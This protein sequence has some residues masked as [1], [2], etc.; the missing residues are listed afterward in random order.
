LTGFGVQVLYRVD[1]WMN[2]SSYFSVLGFSVFM[3]MFVLTSGVI[4]C[5]VGGR[6]SP[7]IVIVP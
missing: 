1:T 4:W 2:N 7:D 5:V 6:S 3:F